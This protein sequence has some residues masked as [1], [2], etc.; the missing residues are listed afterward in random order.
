M[1]LE[2]KK[3]LESESGLSVFQGRPVDNLRLK[4][5]FKAKQDFAFRKTI[6][7]NQKF[8]LSELAGPSWAAVSSYP[9][10]HL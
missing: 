4:L 5:A 10:T 7:G 8:G 6:K 3:N 9:K 2:S 1:N